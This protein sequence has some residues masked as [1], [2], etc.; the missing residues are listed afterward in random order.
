MTRGHAK[1]FLCGLSAREGALKQVGQLHACAD[2]D[3]CNQRRAE[4]V[5][6]RGN[7]A[8]EAAK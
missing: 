1:C 2:E 7:G 6:A 4:R 3:G 8:P 5:R